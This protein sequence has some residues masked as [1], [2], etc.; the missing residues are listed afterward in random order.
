MNIIPPKDKANEILKQLEG[1]GMNKSTALGA[2]DVF[3]THLIAANPTQPCNPYS[4]S[5]TLDVF[6][7][8]LGVQTESKQ[9]LQG[10]AKRKR[11]EKNALHPTDMYLKGNSYL[12]LFWHALKYVPHGYQLQMVNI[13]LE[14]RFIS[15][16][17][18]PNKLIITC[19]LDKNGLLHYIAKND[20]LSI[21][22]CDPVKFYCDLVNAIKNPQE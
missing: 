19:L 16:S 5:P 20:N 18:Y 17:D 10:E 11:I 14:S 15:I 12:K 3:L 7:F 2:M 22:D 4:T 13:D 9:Q 6:K 1:L 8:W 21:N